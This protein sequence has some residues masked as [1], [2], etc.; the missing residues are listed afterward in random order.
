MSGWGLELLEKET[1]QTCNDFFAWWLPRLILGIKFEK[2]RKNLITSGV[3][4]LCKINYTYTTTQI[5]LRL[6]QCFLIQEIN[7]ASHGNREQQC[8]THFL[9]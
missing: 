9:F 8:N 2:K 4:K 7:C 3:T 6:F 5:M 1:L